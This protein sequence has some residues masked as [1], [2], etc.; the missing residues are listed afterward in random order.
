[1]TSLAE[2]NRVLGWMQAAGLASI[3]L[4]DGDQL[5]RMVLDSAPAAPRAA[6][7]APQTQIV[8]PGMGRFL[9]SHPRNPVAPITPGATISAGQ[10]IGFLQLGNTL[11][12]IT[13]DKPGTAV[14]VYPS[15]G[16]LLGYGAPVLSLDQGV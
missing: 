10:I 7:V 1:M 11:T 3:E 2:L 4:R 8:S 12:A 5:L 14:Q 16:D 13:S 9:A 15:D 6:Q